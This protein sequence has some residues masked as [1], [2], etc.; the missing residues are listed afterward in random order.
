MS[1]P[2]AAVPTASLIV[3]GPWCPGG[4]LTLNKASPTSWSK[5]GFCAAWWKG[6]VK[7]EV[8]AAEESEQSS[9]GTGES[10]G[11]GGDL[12]LMAGL[13]FL[14]FLVTFRFF[15]RPLSSSTSGSEAV[16]SV[17]WK[18]TLSVLMYAEEI[19]VLLPALV[20]I[21]LPVLL[22]T[23]GGESESWVSCLVFPPALCFFLVAKACLDVRFG[24]MRVKVEA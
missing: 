11:G 7:D 2:W 22:F 24:A 5:G 23:L 12:A 21:G 1:C 13:L 10:G 4:I 20:R 17:S 14:P 9:E 18:K 8:D 3:K 19:E 6:E 16:D 15:R